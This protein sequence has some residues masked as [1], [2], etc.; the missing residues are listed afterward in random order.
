MNLQ[1][2]QK[3]IGKNHTKFMLKR[4]IDALSR[5]SWFNTV[6]DNQ[7]LEAAKI[8]LKHMKVTE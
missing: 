3:L 8:I 5:I 2:A 6:E 4:Q 1:D 7:R